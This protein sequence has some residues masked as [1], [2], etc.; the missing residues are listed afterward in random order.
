MVTLKRSCTR[1]ELVFCEVV[2]QLYKCVKP[3]VCGVTYG[4]VKVVQK[5]L[6]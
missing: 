1:A 5:G 6:A 2:V 3:K 4:D